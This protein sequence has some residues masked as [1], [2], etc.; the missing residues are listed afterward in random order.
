MCNKE[1]ILFAKKCLSEEHV[2]GK[3]VLEVGSRNIN[4]T[5]RTHAMS[6]GPIEY[7]GVDVAPGEGVDR[8]CS[9]LELVGT[10]GADS[11]GVVIST[12]MLEHVEDW[13][14][15]ISNMKRVLQPGGILVL[16][17]RSYGFGY[18]GC[19]AY[20]DYWRFSLDDMCEIFVDFVDVLV[21]S[22]PFEP[23]VFVRATKPE[24]FIEENL[25]SYRV[26]AIGH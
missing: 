3:R 15:A 14:S 13:Q 19:E 1:C 8:I 23:G 10:F 2:S 20:G 12:E 16:T 11:F 7:V 26:Y 24:T 17:T 4:G 9:A 25:S 21:E 18:H 5:A 22:D 6:L